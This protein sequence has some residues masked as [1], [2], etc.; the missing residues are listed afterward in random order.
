M[1]VTSSPTEA[2]M[3][4]TDFVTAGP[5]PTTR[6]CVVEVCD[7]VTVTDGVSVMVGVSEGVG[8][9][10][11][12]EVSVAVEVMVDVGVFDALMDVFVAT[13]VFEGGEVA[14][15]NGVFVGGEVFEGVGVILAV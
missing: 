4:S 3:P 5:Y 10:V 11:G 1:K 7:G 12:V 13:G 9:S 8:V 15:G 14:E 2:G 6:G